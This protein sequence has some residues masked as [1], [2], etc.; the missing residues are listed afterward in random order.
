MYQDNQ[1]GVK[2]YYWGQCSG[3][4]QFHVG[5]YNDGKDCNPSH[6]GDISQP[7]PQAAKFDTVC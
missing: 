1:S 5:E 6:D 4:Q 3:M 2:Y 7:K